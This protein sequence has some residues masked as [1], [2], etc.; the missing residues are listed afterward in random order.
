M[1]PSASLVAFRFGYGLPLPE[2]APVAPEAMLAALA[3]P[4]EMAQRFAIPGYD[5]V[6]GHVADVALN[7]QAARSDAA[8]QARLDAVVQG[9][10]ATGQMAMRATLA[11]AL[12][13]P[14]GFRERL[15]A[16]WADHFTVGAGGREDA[17]TPYAFVED[18]IRPHLTGRF[19][20]ML[21][22]VVRHPGMLRY[23]DQ[24][25]SVGPNSRRAS[26]RG[27]GLNEN[28]ARELLEL[29]TLGVGAAYTQTDV[30]QL[31]LL[32]TGLTYDDRRGFA[33]DDRMAEPGPK[34][35]FGQTYN[36]RGEAAIAAF[37]HDLAQR[38]DTARH[39][40]QKLAVH[41]LSDTP[42]AGV[43]DAMASAWTASA[44]DLMQVY[45]ALLRHP[46]AQTGPAAKARQPWD[47]LIA[48]F[49]ALGLRGPDL[50]GWSDA[51][52]RNVVILPL[53]AMGQAWKSPPGPDGWD[54]AIE[55]WITPQGLA[56]RIS[57]AMRWPAEIAAPLPDPQVFAQTV[58]GDRAAP[59]TLWACVRAENRA[60]GV[61]IVLASPEFNRR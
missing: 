50:M 52:L 32:L 25:R 30:R 14:D 16:F 9:M 27:G 47:F 59:A 18:A 6:H 35:V 40:A 11:R 37:L 8:L 19:A 45:A 41:F 21:V 17:I 20:D 44:G 56:E 3:A 58:L 51:R 31:A 42:D 61:G 26:R 2:G 4:D 33:Y 49:R 36:G 29:H 24:T 34:T 39:I 53:R 5:W 48:A 46:A 12:E 55:T 60:E 13:A 54:E 7:K 23:L 1:T 10:Q 43:V 57:W 28:L 15:V 38:P 22:A